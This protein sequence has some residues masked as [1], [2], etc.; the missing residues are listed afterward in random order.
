MQKKWN[1]SLSSTILLALASCVG[2]NIVFISSREQEESHL[3]INKLLASHSREN[4]SMQWRPSSRMVRKHQTMRKTATFRR[5]MRKT[6]QQTSR[7]RAAAH[8]G[9]AAGRGGA[10]ARAPSRC[11]PALIAC[12][13][14]HDQALRARRRLT[15]ARFSLNAPSACRSA[16]AWACSIRSPRSR[17]RRS[18]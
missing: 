1:G 14:S 12:H 11:R 10:G 16:R 9:D 4:H 13:V 15:G 5:D 17:A 2:S 18:R 3:D 7:A 6:K 8:A